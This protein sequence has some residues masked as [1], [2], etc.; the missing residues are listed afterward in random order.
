MIDRR[1]L[2]VKLSVKDIIHSYP[3]NPVEGEQ[4]LIQ[5]HEHGDISESLN[6]YIIRRKGSNW[7]EIP[8]R[9][10]MPEIINEQNGDILSYDG[11]KWIAVAR[12]G[13]VVVDDI[14]D[15]DYT[16]EQDSS[17][18]NVIGT[19]F[20]STESYGDFYSQDLHYSVGSGMNCLEY[21]FSPGISFA[22]SADRKIYT[23]T[24]VGSWDNWQISAPLN[25]NT[26]I[27]SKFTGLL[28]YHNG[29]KWEAFNSGGVILVDDVVLFNHRGTTADNA[30]ASVEG[31]KYIECPAR[32]DYADRRVFTVAAEGSVDSR[33][34]KAHE[35]I[36]VINDGAIFYYDDNAYGASY[37][38]KI[39]IP[40]NNAVIISKLDGSTYY[41]DSTNKKLV[42]AGGNVSDT[43]SSQGLVNEAFTL[44]SSNI[45]NKSVTL[46]GSVASGKENSVLCF[47]GGAVHFAGSD[48]TAA[49]KSISWNNKTLDSAGLA[50]G[51]VLVVQYESA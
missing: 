10:D 31:N 17:I 35:V 44:E 22:C 9:Y 43:S 15:F 8:P 11:S 26:V 16:G 38:E 3:Q 45:S 23:Y 47:I 14:I 42:K 30:L 12:C 32:S 19:K 36:A 37:P 46:S 50:E 20:I 5:A 28:Y 33:D 1:F 40:T 34:T 13:I 6:N 18:N 39:L 27:M 49:A 41:Y 24:K 7:E 4:Y 25:S 21:R 29:T 51:D 48:F 2:K